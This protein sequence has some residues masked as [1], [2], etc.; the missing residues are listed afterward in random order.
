MQIY[1]KDSS[2]GIKSCG[3]FPKWHVFPTV[4]FCH[5]ID[6]NVRHDKAPPSCGCR[7]LHFSEK[8]SE[9]RSLW[10][11]LQGCGLEW[12]NPTSLG[13]N[14]RWVD[15]AEVEP[16]P[17]SPSFMKTPVSRL[18][19]AVKEHFLGANWEISILAPSLTRNST[20]PSYLMSLGLGLFICIMGT[21]ML[22]WSLA[23]RFSETKGVLCPAHSVH[24]INIGPLPSWP[25][26]GMKHC[27]YSRTGP[28]SCLLLYFPCLTWLSYR[29][30]GG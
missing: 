12:P 23:V 1:D 27:F 11:K 22:P 20:L 29:I 3:E 15:N 5:G 8:D 26:T 7:G 14:Q 6:Q 4:F 18:C 21:V 25:L 19:G 30:G 13:C 24:S 17:L 10:P 9:E 2:P 28:L 16:I